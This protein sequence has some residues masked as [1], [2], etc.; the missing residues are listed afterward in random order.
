MLKSLLLGMSRMPVVK[1]VVVAFPLTRRVVDRFVAGETLE[2]CLNVTKALV[3]SGLLVLSLKLMT[4]L[5]LV[6][7]VWSFRLFW[8]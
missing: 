7:D 5:W 6:N 1:K 4:P 2:E 8:A 3:S